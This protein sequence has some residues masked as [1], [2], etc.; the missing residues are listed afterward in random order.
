MRFTTRTYRTT[1]FDRCVELMNDTW[2]FNEL[3][4]GLGKPNLINEL[5]F[6]DSISVA[7]Y[8]ELIVDES[9]R[10]HGYLFGTLEPT[11]ADTIRRVLRALRFR[12]R[13]AYHFLVGDFGSR[14]TAARR[15][16]ELDRL[17]DALEAKRRDGDGYVSLFFVGSSLRGLGW[18]RRLMENFAKQCHERGHDRIYLWTDKGCNF[19]FYDHVGFE[20]IATVRSPLL[21]DYGPQPNGFVYV[22][23]VGTG[24]VHS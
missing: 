22:R 20:R 24:A 18:G 16:S 10:A 5:F 12:A 9:D 3:F 6:Q 19:G 8:S 13:I 4:P 14:R 23:P 1:D 7:N 21:A 17:D 2:N 15:G 11:R